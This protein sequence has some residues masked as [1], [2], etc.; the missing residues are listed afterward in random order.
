MHHVYNMEKFNAGSGFALHP[1]IVEFM[2]F[3]DF[4]VD[5]MSI[6]NGFNNQSHIVK[7]GVNQT[8]SDSFTA[9]SPDAS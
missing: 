9:T 7:F 3:T 1:K 8:L 6:F 2:P 4:K 5:W